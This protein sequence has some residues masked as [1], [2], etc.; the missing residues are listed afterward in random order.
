MMY[1]WPGNF[2]LVREERV[3]D[4]VEDLLRTRAEGGQGRHQD[5]RDERDDQGVFHQ[6]LARG[7]PEPILQLGDLPDGAR[8]EMQQFSCAL[9]GGERKSPRT[10]GLLLPAVDMVSVQA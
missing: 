2:P 9:V 3:R 7:S 1:G 10:R 4:R 8:V 6:S 5:D